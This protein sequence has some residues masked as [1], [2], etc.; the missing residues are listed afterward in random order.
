MRFSQESRHRTLKLNPVHI[1][2]AFF[3]GV[4]AWPVSTGPQGFADD[5]ISVFQSPP[6]D[7]RRPMMRADRAIAERRYAD[8]A[9]E[10]GRLLLIESTE[11]AESQDYFLMDADAGDGPVQQSFRSQIQQ[12]LA[13]L[14]AEGRQA[15]ELQYGAQAR[16]ALDQALSDGDMDRVADVIR[17]F[18][19]TQAGYEASVLAG[20]YELGRGRPMAAAL[21]LDRVAR[22]PA[23]AVRFEPELSFLLAACWLYS[24]MPDK[25]RETLV[26]MRGRVSGDAI[27]LGDQQ[28]AMFREDAEAL[29]WFEDL[30]GQR[31]PLLAPELTQWV[32]HRGNAQRN[33]RTQG[34]LPLLSYRWRV[35][36]CIDR[37][38]EM[39]I[40]KLGKQYRDEARA[41]IPALQ[42]LAV[43]DTILMRTPHKL[44]GVDFASGKRIWVWPPW[45]GDSIDPWS[46]GADRHQVLAAQ[47]EQEVQQRIWDD[48]AHGQISSDGRS[49]F[50]VHELG[51]APAGTHMPNR[52]LMLRGGMGLRSS[53]DARTTNQLVSLSL[54]RQGAAEWIVG[55]ESGEDEPALA[56]A[57]F[58]GPPLPLEGNLY[59]MIE[60]NG[61][62][63][64]VVLNAANGR[65]VWQQQLAHVESR[66]IEVDGVRRLVGAMPSYE[67]GVLICPTSAGAVVAV[68]RAARSLLWGYQYLDAPQQPQHAGLRAAQLARR[69]PQPVDSRWIDSTVTMADGRVLV[70]PAETDDLHCLDLLTGEPVW[71]PQPR[72]D[73]LYVACVHHGKVI[74]VGPEQMTAIQLKDGQAAWENPLDLMDPPSGRGLYTGQ[75][76]FL[77]TMGSELLKIDLDSGQ[78]VERTMTSIVLGNLVAYRDEILSHGPQWLST[79]YQSEPLQQR[80]EETLARDPDDLEALGQY[81]ELLLAQGRRD[82][83]IEKL[84]LVC[85]QS[86]ENTMT[87]SLLADTL[88]AALQEDFQGRLDTVDEI[89]ALVEHPSQ[90][91]RLLRLLASG[92]QQQ[93]EVRKAFEA[94]L[95]LAELREQSL[96]ESSVVEREA[97]QIERHWNC[98]TERW[99]QARFA[100]LLSVADVE[101]RAM[102]DQAIGRWRDAALAEGEISSMRGFLRYFDTHPW[103]GEIR[104]R[105]AERLVRTGELVEAQLL[106]SSLERAADDDLQRRM[107]L[108]LAQLLEQ[109]RQF[110]QALHQYRVLSERWGDVEFAEGST[111]TELFAAALAR[112]EFQDAARRADPWPTGHVEISES[113]EQVNRYPSYRRVFSSRTRQRTFGAPAGM[114]VFYDQHPNTLIVRDGL[115]NTIQTVNLGARRLNTADFSL[116]HAR[117]HGHLLMVSVGMEVLAI[118]LMQAARNAS[119]AIKWRR[120]LIRPAHGTAIY[121]TQVNVHTLR[122]PWGDTRRVFAD[123]EKNLIGVTGPLTYRGLFL[124]NLREL[125]CADPVTGDTIWS[126]TNLPMGSDVF[127]DDELIFV[128]PPSSQTAYV[129]GALDGQELGTREVDE[130]DYRWATSGRNVLAWS[131]ASAT[132][133]LTLR[134]Y[135]VWTGEEHWREEVPAE[136][137]ATLIEEDEVALLQPD[138]RLVIR[139]LGGDAVL[140]ETQV[141][142]EQGLLSLYVIR[143][144][145]QYLVVTNRTA[146]VE[147]NTPAASIRSIVSGT[148][149]PLV[150]GH[151]YAFDRGTGQSVWEEPFPVDR[152]G[153]PEDQPS[154]SPVLL[155]LRHYRPDSTRGTQQHTAMLALARHDGRQVMDKGDIPAQTYTYDVTAD[156][157]QQSVTIGLPSRNIT[158]KMTDNPVP[159]PPDAPEDQPE[160]DV[161]DS[162]QAD[163][164]RA[165]A[166]RASMPRGM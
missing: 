110:D 99:L 85:Q 74:L 52:F 102:M 49:V 159:E 148:A 139:S 40:E 92:W 149:T 77:P 84:R 72:G 61:E 48:A 18:F 155:L 57:F 25:A 127:G 112:A 76:Y 146:R 70:T 113:T 26:T 51:Y 104:L 123:R 69:I 124:M 60:V 15:Y 21:H 28:V 93:G 5:G 120:E 133:P 89:R 154:E 157:L 32:L 45:E 54:A 9:Y 19:H 121:H 22:M 147:P 105:L 75:H 134:L 156:R 33:A 82:E 122:H 151:A 163:A 160:Q 136:S 116:I 14:P 47:R 117:L 107:A 141:Q 35:P 46:G 135:D 161:G 118:D 108:Q 71:E 7:V 55:G 65:L 37:A 109:G 83:A 158:M 56:G 131:Q 39:L 8:A 166:T 36:T 142:P 44:L 152:F 63:R 140:V 50:L 38:D 100:E 68:D 114:R 6:S 81:G 91:I 10:L 143:S 1:M 42:P 53:S 144:Q 129:F 162:D 97:E 165:D 29:D 31:P 106:L 150:S 4:L 95:G 164:G 17:R 101:Q 24:E 103:A 13:A 59:G 41:A 128:V 64:L 3:M 96:M 34:S 58:L 43:G 23:A 30:V 153:F 66:T 132:E 90:E 98:R 12:K 20:R 62:I 126:R 119:A 138:G 94:Y 125:V 115:G 88:L 67:G 73:H 137:R 130:L 111:G 2:L 16:A 11:S 80:V 145:Q 79:F 78:I 27:R 86:P 87:R